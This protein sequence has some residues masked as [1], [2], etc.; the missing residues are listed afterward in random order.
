MQIMNPGKF[1]KDFWWNFTAFN[2]INALPDSVI[3]VNTD[4]EIAHFNRKA[5][6]VLGL[7]NEED[8]VVKFNELIKDGMNILRK[9]A[10]SVK[11]VMATV[12]ASGLEFYVEINAANKF[13][14]YIVTLRDVTKLTKEFDNDDKTIKFN[15]EKNAMLALLEDDIKAPISSISGFSRG[16]LDGIGGDL[17]D[18]QAKYVQIINNNSNELFAFMSKF[19]Q[20]SKA[21]SS[22][23]E[24]DYHNF[25]ITESFKAVA[26]EFAELISAKKLEFDIDGNALEKR[27]VN[28]DFPSVKDAFRNI[29]EV[30]IMMTES[31]YISVKLA[32]PDEEKCIK[33]SLNPEDA[34]YYVDVTIKNTA[35]IPE[36]EMKYLCEP[37]AQ[38]EKGKK[39]LLRALILGSASIM[40]KRAEGLFDIYSDANGT[41]FTMILP[42]E[43]R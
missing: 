22:I 4:G 28:M 42:V 23:Y 41:R 13:G 24:S 18:K 11:P 6:Q 16:L 25:D 34:L 17:T 40:I 19:L 39:N 14:G 30:A 12:S 2:T 8:G 31:G 15:N 7:T 26:A 1:L 43:K 27:N 35:T 36:D 37:Y 21:E 3:F 33:Y 20:F 38:L 9:S 10:D 5:Q 29:L 32:H